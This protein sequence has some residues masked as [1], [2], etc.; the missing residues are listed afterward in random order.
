[1][2]TMT[3]LNFGAFRTHFVERNISKTVL[4]PSFQIYTLK[5]AFCTELYDENFI[6]FDMHMGNLPKNGQF[7]F[8][9]NDIFIPA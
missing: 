3:W 1:M 2:N 7:L 8:L 5:M 4:D 9:K 6:D